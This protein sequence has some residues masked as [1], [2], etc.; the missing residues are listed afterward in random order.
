MLEILRHDIR[1]SV[2]SCE[3]SRSLRQR[4]NYVRTSELPRLELSSRLL[5]AFF[6]GRS[7]S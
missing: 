6:F 3:S 7:A 4:C 1:D 5:T 2:R